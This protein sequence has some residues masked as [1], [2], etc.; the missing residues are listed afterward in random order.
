VSVRHPSACTI[1]RSCNGV[2]AAHGT[3]ARSRGGPRIR[4]SRR[5]ADTRVSRVALGMEVRWVRSD[6]A[7]RPMTS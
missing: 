6:T 5:T 3:P 4:R 2:V 7:R 1:P